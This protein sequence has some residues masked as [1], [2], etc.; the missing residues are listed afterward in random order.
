MV[1]AAVEQQQITLQSLSL[2]GG[3]QGPVGSVVLRLNEL[4]GVHQAQAAHIPNDIVLL[5]QV[6]ELAADNFAHLLHILKDAALI[7]LFQN[8]QGG[9]AGNGVAAVGSAV[10][11]LGPLVHDLLLAKDSGQRQAASDGL[12]GGKNVRLYAQSLPGVQVA[13]AAKA[14]LDFVKDQHDAVFVTQLTDIL[15]PLHWGDHIAALA[16]N[17]LHHDRR[18]HRGIHDL[19]EDLIKLSEILLGALA[20]LHL[21]GSPEQIGILGKVDA[22][23]HG[24]VVLA[25]GSVGSG[26]SRGC[27]GTAVEGVFH[28]DD[29][30]TLGC[31]LRQLHGALVGLSSGVGEIHLVLI[32]GL[33]HQLLHQSSIG[34]IV[35]NVMSGVD[36]S[37]QLLLS[38]SD[39]LGVAVAEG[40]RGNTG[41]HIQNLPAILRI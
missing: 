1:G 28:G 18:Y 30:R 37:M 11:A 24:L 4:D 12:R 10:S 9:R 17:R 39:H 7:Q 27:H 40:V 22:G 19:L 36:Q 21:V 8:R 38:G 16:L 41:C 35:Q 32:A 23:H 3:A 34:L 2:D 13:G 29:D 26:N 25:V 6:I 33:L 14:R 15:Q 20:V 31:V 5:L